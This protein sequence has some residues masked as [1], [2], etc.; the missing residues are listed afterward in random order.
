[1]KDIRTALGIPETLPPLGVREVWNWLWLGFAGLLLLLVSLFPNLVPFPWGGILG[2]V[3]WLAL[4]VCRLF[5]Q[6]ARK[7]PT[8]DQKRIAAQARLCARIVVSFGIAFAIWA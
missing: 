6:S 1:M 8:D 2:L 3:C 7:P 5:S 4:P